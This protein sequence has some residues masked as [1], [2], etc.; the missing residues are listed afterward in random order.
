M[1]YDLVLFDLDGTLLDTSLGIFNSVRYAEN[2]MGFKR[3][4]DELLVQFVGPPPKVMYKKMYD[5]SDEDAVNATN[6][7]REY[8]VRKAIYEAKMYDKVDDVLQYIKNKGVKTGVATLKSQYIAEKVLDIA[9]IRKFFDI[10]VGMDE[11]ETLTKCDIIKSAINKTS[12][13]GNVLMV[14]DSQYDYEGA[15]KAGIEFVGALYGF[16]FEHGKHYPF[17]TIGH[18]KELIDYI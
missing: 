10:I 5:V 16:G 6:F 8:G 1:K 14:G 12:I 15:I 7:H 17:Y 11:S 9:R 18:I 4:A 2:Q 13:K 3:I